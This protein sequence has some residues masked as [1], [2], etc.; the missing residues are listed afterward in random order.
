MEN[1]KEKEIIE[2]TVKHFSKNNYLIINGAV[3]YEVASFLNT[4]FL[5]KRNA[6]EFLFNNKLISPFEETWGHW[7]DAQIPNT[8]SHYGDV[9]MDTLLERVLPTMIKYTGLDLV[10]TYSYARIYK[11]GDELKRHKD[12]ESCEI[13]CTCNLGGE[14]WPIYLDPTGNVGNEGVEVILQP[15]DILIYKGCR[16]EH[17]RKPF[18]GNSCT[19]VFLHYNDKNGQFLENNIYDTRP[20][21]GL[22]S[23]TKRDN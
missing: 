4:Y 2:G 12:R 23:Y 5:N 9:A 18:E 8:Y 1:K 10:P 11:Y 13:S 22:P 16:L 3:P 20:L 21:I 6:T 19:Q 17:W 7:N 15:G 14:L